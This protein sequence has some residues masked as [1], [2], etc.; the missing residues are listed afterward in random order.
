MKSALISV[1]FLV[2]AGATFAANLVIHTPQFN[3]GIDPLKPIVVKVAI[4]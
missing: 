3:D 4:H 1:A 2:L